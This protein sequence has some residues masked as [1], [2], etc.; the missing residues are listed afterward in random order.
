MLV[1]QAYNVTLFTPSTL[2]YI[3]ADFLEYGIINTSGFTKRHNRSTH[4]LEVKFRSLTVGEIIYRP[5]G[6]DTKTTCGLYSINVCTQEAELPS[7]FCFLPLNLRLYFFG[8]VFTAGVF[9][10][11]CDDDKSVNS[12]CL[13][14]VP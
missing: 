12:P 9:F 11:I 1:D 10:A 8:G 3:F 6:S 5:V 7:I 2:P 13:F 4:N 14:P